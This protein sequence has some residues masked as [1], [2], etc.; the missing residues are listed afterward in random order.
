MP[1]G[2]GAYEYT[3]VSS[4]VPYSYIHTDFW[5]LVV[6]MTMHLSLNTVL[7]VKSYFIDVIIQIN[8]KLTVR[9]TDRLTN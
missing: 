3:R 2:L 6:H 8:S 5:K 1:S 7:K 4:P 9:L